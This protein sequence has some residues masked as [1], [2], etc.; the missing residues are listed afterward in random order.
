MSAE[1]G[2]MLRYWEELAFLVE[3]VHGCHAQ[4]AGADAQGRVLDSL[5]FGGVGAGKVG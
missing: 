4:G 5:E 1:E 2:V 3:V